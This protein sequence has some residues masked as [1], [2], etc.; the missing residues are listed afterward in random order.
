MNPYADMRMAKAQK[1]REKQFPANLGRSICLYFLLILYN[2][3]VEYKVK[4]NHFSQS[5]HVHAT[6]E[7]QPVREPGTKR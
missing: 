2:I 5:I 4:Y 7:K 1:Y 6:E 3:C